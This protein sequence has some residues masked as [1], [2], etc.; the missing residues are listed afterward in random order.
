[1]VNVSFTS[2]W[3]TIESFLSGRMYM[4]HG[5]CYLWQTPLV[6]LHLVSNLLTAIA[7]FSIPI[8]LV[9]FT[10]KRQDTPFSRVFILFSIFILACGVGHALEMII[11]WF[12]IYWIDGIERAFT[13]LISCYTAIE[14]YT[15]L[16]KF[17]ALK[18][19]EELAL[20]NQ[21]L[22]SEI[23]ERKKAESI[24]N[25]IVA[26]TAAVTGRDFF[27]ALAENLAIALDV[28]QVKISETLESPTKE[29]QLLATWDNPK[30]TNPESAIALEDLAPGQSLKFPI[31]D[32]D[33]RTIG[34]LQVYHNQPTID[35]EQATNLITIFASRAAAEIERKRALDE[36]ASAN[37]KLEEI[38]NQLEEKV[39]ERTI[40]LKTVNQT[41]KTRIE[42]LRQTEEA[43][44]SSENR[45]RSLILNIPGAVYRCRPDEY[46]T[47]EFLSYG[48]EA[49]TGYAAA[50]FI[51]NTISPFSAIIYPE[52]NARIAN[53]LGDITPQHPTYTDEYRLI[54]ADKQVRWVSEQG[55]GIFD[56]QGTLIRLEGVMID[57]TDRKLSDLR[58]ELERKQLRQVIL[59]APL[60]MAMFDTEMRYIAHSEQWL[61]DYGLQG[62]WIIGRSHYEVLPNLPKE[63]RVAHERALRG[64]IVVCEEDQFKRADG[65]VYYLKWKLQPWYQSDGELGGII[66]ISQ[67]I[68][69]LVEARETAIATAQLKSSFLAN[70]SHEIRTPMNGIL[71]ITELLQTTKLNPQQEAFVSTLKQ[72]AN[73]LLYIINDILDF[74]KL[75]A[76][77]MRLESIDL[78][79]ID[80][81]ESVAELSAF[82]A[83]LKPVEVITHID[84]SLGGTFLGDPVRLRQI[85][86]NLIG[87]AIKFTHQGSVMVRAFPVVTAASSVMVK[88]EIQDTGIGISQVDQEK[89]FRSF[90]QVDPSTTREYGG[91][92]LG[93]AIAKHLVT[94]MGGEIGLDS[95]PGQGST[96]WFTARFERL[97]APPAL[98]VLDPC[99]VLLID[100]QPLSCRAIQEY[101]YYFG[102]DVVAEGDFMGGLFALEQQD[103]FDLVFLTV[104]KLAIQAGFETAL[105][106]V[107]A[108]LSRKNL[109]LLLSA[110]DYPALKDWLHKQGIRYLLKPIQQ[111]ALLDYLQTKDK[112]PS[113]FA[114][115]PSPETIVEFEHLAVKDVRILLVEDTPINQTVI[116]NQLE[117]LGF[118]TVDCVDNGRQALTQLANKTYDLI[119][120]D[121]LMP[122]L[123]GYMTTEM[124]RQR[125]PEGT[126]QLII[127]MTANAMKGDR[128]KCLAAGMDGYI[129]KPT[130]IHTLGLVLDQCL[131]KLSVT[132]SAQTSN[133]TTDTTE[134]LPDSRDFEE[135]TIPEEDDGPINLR[136]LGRFYGDNPSF[137]REMFEQFM[138]FAP[139]YVYALHRAIADQDPEKISYEAHRLKGAASSASIRKIPEWCAAIELALPEK[140]YAAIEDLS[141]DIRDYF[142]QVMIFIQ[143]YLVP[144][145]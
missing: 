66:R 6:G 99:R 92:G 117:I 98:P 23:Q 122:E 1:M 132:S 76:G 22:Q 141:Q 119:L 7:Y 142:E 13:A 128:E 28:C 75:E 145:T 48:I 104:P 11:L 116:L 36:L 52:D 123:D 110:V 97:V 16:P 94:L 134:A 27:S 129:A 144:K 113:T 67:D 131:Q 96:F 59:N 9:Y 47:M 29:P 126:H 55:R 30:F 73:H 78:E 15:L 133:S 19:P 72:S 49:I 124:I 12:P 51:E 17:L 26:G 32:R 35:R 44:R 33:S 83:G 24:L 90:S 58:L 40:A 39:A 89:L 74:S 77:E 140:N 65:S 21:K 70:M 53:T 54:H 143:S 102:M 130:S 95:I 85:L 5:S 62:Q 69:Q 87:N 138:E 118:K 112:D 135:T 127:A 3:D 91:T 61:I 139:G 18:S 64:E 8:M 101:L 42:D 93:L 43:L 115:P 107:K 121:C 86:M 79:I 41:L 14:L 57:I 136:Q 2:I 20:V 137:H 81:V 82:Q 88:F 38:N 111:Q 46:W 45:Y 100:S 63:W 60:P 103:N 4:P 106:K 50:N 109:V 71:G 25:R 31:Q 84:P 34:S 80:C 125:E 56:E 105:E 68:S 120:M 37:T 108:L 10:K 114:L